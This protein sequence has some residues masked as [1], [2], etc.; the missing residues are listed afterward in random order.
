M[1]AVFVGHKQVTIKPDDLV[2]TPSGRTALCI[3][4]RQAGFRL[5]ED[6]ATGQRSIMHVDDLYL[7]R[8]AKPKRWA[9]HFLGW[10]R[11]DA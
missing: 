8:A 5:I 3:E 6:S 10:G 2:R 4:I 1:S 7:V 9:D 11:V